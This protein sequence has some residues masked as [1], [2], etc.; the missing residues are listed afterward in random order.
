LIGG[1]GDGGTAFSFAG[2]S[3]IPTVGVGGTGGVAGNAAAASASNLVN[4][5]HRPV[6]VVQQKVLIRNPKKNRPASDRGDF[7]AGLSGHS[8]RLHPAARAQIMPIPRTNAA[9]PCSNR[10][11]LQDAVLGRRC[12]N[13]GRARTGQ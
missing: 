3:A 6:F 13:F 2:S 10:M 8:Q 7:K 1:G 12:S 5:W 9:M 11:L 4:L